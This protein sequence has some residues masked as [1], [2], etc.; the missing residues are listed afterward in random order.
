[1]RGTRRKALCR[2]RR[3]AESWGAQRD[4]IRADFKPR[5]T[6]SVVVF[7]RVVFHPEGNHFASQR[8][9]I[10]LASAPLDR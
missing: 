4:I 1:M 2:Y 5:L 6:D 10:A 9:V 7:A 8:G 3:D